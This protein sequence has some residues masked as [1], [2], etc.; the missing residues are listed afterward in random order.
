MD[1]AG[2]TRFI[3]HMQAKHE[4]II[5][6]LADACLSLAHH[7]EETSRRIKDLSQ[8]VSETSQSIKELR[9]SHARSDRHL[10]ALV[11]VTEKLA[12]HGRKAA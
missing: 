5:R 9:I 2:T 12:V 7:G 10:D 11:D 1:I 3:L 6:K 4:I 8:L